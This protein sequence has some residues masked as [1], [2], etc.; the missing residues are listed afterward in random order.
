MAVVTPKSCIKIKFLTSKTRAAPAKP[1][2][3]PRLKLLSFLLLSILR[4][5]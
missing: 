4:I 5:Y 1:L 3:I 2:T